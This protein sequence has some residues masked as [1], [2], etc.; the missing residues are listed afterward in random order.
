M[1]SCAPAAGLVPRRA[2]RLLRAAGLRNPATGREYLILSCCVRWRCRLRSA[3]VACCCRCCRCFRRIC[4]V[5][6]CPALPR[7]VV[8]Q[9]S[10]LGL[11]A[12]EPVR[13]RERL[14]CRGV[15]AA[16]PGRRRQLQRGGRRQVCS[17]SDTSICASRPAP[18]CVVVVCSHCM[19]ILAWLR[20]GAAR[21]P[22]RRTSP[23]SSSCARVAGLIRVCHHFIFVPQ[24]SGSSVMAASAWAGSGASARSASSLTDWAPLRGEALL[25]RRLMSWTIPLCFVLTAWRV[26][27]ASLRAAAA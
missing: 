21:G 6:P 23:A 27:P 26:L 7:P 11:V 3:F 8:L 2:W 18:L 19:C 22:T 20:C 4:A 9:C 17:P 10:R 12:A 14:L 5:P 13:Q 24:F 25:G 16:A 15:L 1:C